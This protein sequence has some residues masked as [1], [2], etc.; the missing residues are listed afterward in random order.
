MYVVGRRKHMTLGDIQFLKKVGI[1]PCSLGDPSSGPLPVAPATG[2]ILMAAQE[3][4]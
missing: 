4:E 1:E 2:R 3:S